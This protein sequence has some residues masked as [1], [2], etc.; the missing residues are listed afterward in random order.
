V[1]ITD[2]VVTSSASKRTDCQLIGDV[3]YLF[4]SASMLNRKAPDKWD[5][6]RLENDTPPE[7]TFRCLRIWR[8]TPFPDGKPPLIF[9]KTH[10]VTWPASSLTQARIL[11]E[12]SF[13]TITSKSIDARGG[14]RQCPQ[15]IDAP[16]R[17]FNLNQKIALFME[18]P[19]R[20]SGT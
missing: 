19:L 6:R 4:I 2:S 1:V 11:R 9:D 12:L 17:D 8:E 15:K 13:S 18:Q 5:S 14:L 16:L 3:V 10:Y 20:V 7:F